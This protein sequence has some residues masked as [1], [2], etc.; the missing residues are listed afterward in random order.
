MIIVELTSDELPVDDFDVADEALSLSEAAPEVTA[1][2]ASV[3]AAE[4]DLAVE[5]DTVAVS[6]DVCGFAVET[7]VVTGSLSALP[8]SA[9]I[10]SGMVTTE[11]FV[12]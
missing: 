3:L 8:L 5:P 7:D 12:V 1:G 6:A 2:K 4:A 10:S 9:V 11:E